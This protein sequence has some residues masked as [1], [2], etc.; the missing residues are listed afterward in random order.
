[1]HISNFAKL[2][3]I[4]NQKKKKHETWAKKVFDIERFIQ[5]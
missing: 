4:P 3:V 5:Q 1:M 2:G